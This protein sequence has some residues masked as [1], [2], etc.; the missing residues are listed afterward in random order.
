MSND[1]ELLHAFANE[2]SQAAF[3]ELVSRH[4]D[5]VYSVA[6]RRPANRIR[7]RTSLKRHSSYWQRRRRSYDQAGAG[8]MAVCYGSFGRK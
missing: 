3:A 2:S 8:G 1:W 6:L 7:L 5:L 4:M